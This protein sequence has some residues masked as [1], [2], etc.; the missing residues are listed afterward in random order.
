MR[1]AATDRS[2]PGAAESAPDLPDLDRVVAEV[3]AAVGLAEGRS[4]V[5]DVVR[6]IVRAEPVAVRELARA[7]EMP[8]PIVTAVCNELRARG[9]VDR[10][11]PVQLTAEA[12]GALA[13]LRPVLSGRCPTCFGTGFTVPG[14][15]APVAA[16]LDRLAATMPAA[17]VELDQTHCTVETK[18]RRVLALYETGALVGKRLL[19]LGDDDL[20]SL[21][22][23]AFAAHTGI[24]AT[25]PGITVVDVDRDLLDFLARSATGAGVDVEVV[26]HDARRP[27][28]GGLREAF[29]T[30][31]TDPPYTPAGAE[32]FLSRAVSALT[33]DAGQHVFLSF[34]ARRPDETLAT[35]ALIASM[36]LVTRSLTPGFNSYAGAGI[37]AGTSHLYHL[38]GTEG[39][40]PSI[41]DGYDGPLYTAETRSAPS[42]PYRCAR[43]R[44]VHRVGPGERWPRIADLQDAGCPDCGGSVF[45]P[46]ALSAR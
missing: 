24:A 22:V 23:A 8:V 26:E 17:R 37:L 18:I 3:A 45:R 1:T 10:N 6:E 35:Q 13:D 29:D 15:L 19:V 30:V 5:R 12:R 21:A 25:L 46:M 32:L 44:A 33:P 2:G 42:R 43:C 28:P 11:R 20:T 41:V 7:A 9:V 27:L 40:A 4:G 14:G 39:A 31:C 36:G 16:E 34:G 38:R